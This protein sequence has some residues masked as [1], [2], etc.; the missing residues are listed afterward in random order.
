MGQF[1]RHRMRSRNEVGMGGQ[2][3]IDHLEQLCYVNLTSTNLTLYL[4]Y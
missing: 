1:G 2:T 3:R 4:N